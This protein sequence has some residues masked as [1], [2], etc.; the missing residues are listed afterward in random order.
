MSL[1]LSLY[2]LFLWLCAQTTGNER[3]PQAAFTGAQGKQEMGQIVPDAHIGGT[4]EQSSKR[5]VGTGEDNCQG[6]SQSNGEVTTQPPGNAGR[7]RGYGGTSPIKG[8]AYPCRI[9]GTSKKSGLHLPALE[10][11]SFPFG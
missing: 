5:T 9:A 3:R 2:R 6:Y 8:G 11:V 1:T 4:G 10:K 7:S